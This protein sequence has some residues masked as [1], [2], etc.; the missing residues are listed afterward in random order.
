MWTRAAER[1]GSATPRTARAGP[2]RS[3]AGSPRPWR[4]TS[5]PRTPPPKAATTSSTASLRQADQPVDRIR[6]VPRLPGR[7]R[8]PPLSGRAAPALAAPRL[9]RRQP[10]GLGRT[11]RG[12]GR[13]AALPGVLHGPCR[14]SRHPVL[15]EADRGRLPRGDGQGPGPVR[16]R[17]PRTAR[18]RAVSPRPA[19]PP[20]LAGRWL[21]KFFTGHLAGERAAS[22]KTIS[23]Y[24]DAMKLLLTWFRDV[25]R[26]PPEKLRLADIDRPR[27]LRFLDWLEAGRCCSAA[28]RNQRL[29]VIK[30]FCRYT[31]VEQ[32]DH[33]DQVT[34][35]LAIRQKKT[36]APQLD[37]LTGD[38]VRTLLAEPGTAS[39]RAVRDTVLLALAYDTAARVQ[40]LCDLDVADIRR[41]RPMTVVIRGKGSKIRYV[42]VME[43]T[44]QL[45]DD[46]LDH[47]DRHP[48][49]GADADP[50]FAGPNHSRLTR[51]GVAKLLA[52]HVR[53]VRARDPGWAP[54]LPVTP[55]TLRRSRAMH[56]IQAGVNLIYIRDLLGHADV[57]TT[58]IYARADA[59]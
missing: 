9:R 59:Q 2:C 24:R 35:V 15:P 34:Q 54:G 16:L 28:T 26:I 40:E 19:P 20:D 56:L 43:P 37:H 31:A 8:H 53:A 4:A 17:R 55:H 33:L 52:R 39:A 22:P 46:Y 21:S 47:R 30:S 3:P 32:P 25:E 23:S 42:P 48:G 29:A 10:Q 6:A 5:R 14:P 11:R 51:Y 50:L 7:R 36:P 1:C 12:P 18:G 38:E 57:S 27:V 41:G 45:V 44:A 58:E 13:D 49:V